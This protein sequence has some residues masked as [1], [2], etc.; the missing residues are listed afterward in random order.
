MTRLIAERF[1]TPVANPAAAGAQV[2]RLMQPE[3]KVV[4]VAAN[5]VVEQIYEQMGGTNGVR[6]RKI[7]ES[8]W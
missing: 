3:L 6:S 1:K 4:P 8:T 5:T 7:Y 2:A